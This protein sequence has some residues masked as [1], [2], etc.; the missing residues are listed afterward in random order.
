MGRSFQRPKLMRAYQ[1]ERQAKIEDNKIALCEIDIP[2]PMANQ[3]RIKVEAC[4]ICHTDLH[5]IEGDLKA[6]R[7]PLTPGH[8]V[9]GLID[10][11]GSEVKTTGEMQRFA[12]GQR[13]GVPWIHKTCGHCLNCKNGKENLCESAKFTG[14]DYDGGFAQYMVAEADSII[15]L[16]EDDDPLKV[17]PFLCAGI[18]GYR[19][20]KKAM[21]NPG[22]FV[23]L[24]GFGASAH[25]MLPILNHLGA[26]VL[27]FTRS[28]HHQQH[29]IQLGAIW[30]GAPKSKPPKLLNQAIIFTPSGE[31]VQDALEVLSG[32]GIV[33]IN[34]IHMSDIP[35]LTYASIYKERTITSVTNSTR[36]DAHEFLALAR[37]I[38][39]EPTTVVYQFDEFNQALSDLKASRFN[40]EAVL[41]I[42]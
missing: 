1:I 32:G 24:F 13:V 14:Y 21:V 8:Q 12:V 28:Q 2:T 42:I 36:S 33:V 5:I 23:G 9:V 26:K 15:W 11:L 20:V 29:A 4:G 25:L 6:G 35:S 38:H 7:L 17:A 34:A 37:E 22:D 41:K 31:S 3:I 40:G 16:Q 27:V 19:A 18:V 39:L 30:A 10:M